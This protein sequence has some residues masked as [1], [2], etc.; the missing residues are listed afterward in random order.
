MI[1]FPNSALDFPRNSKVQW[2]EHEIPS[3]IFLY[4]NCCGRMIVRNRFYRYLCSLLEQSIRHFNFE[5]S[6]NKPESLRCSEYV[7]SGGG[8]S[9]SL[10]MTGIA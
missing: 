5:H 9:R 8:L 3:W 7:S 10:S 2:S 1:Q 4:T 6:K